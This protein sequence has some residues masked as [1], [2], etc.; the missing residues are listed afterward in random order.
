MKSDLQP[1]E[2]APTAPLDFNQSDDEDDEGDGSGDVIIR[3]VPE[4]E[5]GSEA[6]VPQIVPV[7]PEGGT[8]AAPEE[9]EE[10]PEIMIVPIPPPSATEAQSPPTSP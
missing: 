5:Q 8:E 10:Q 3:K 7:A 4:G 6:Q 9:A 1:P 2:G